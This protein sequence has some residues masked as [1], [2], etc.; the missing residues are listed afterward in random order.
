M[1]LLNDN[2]FRLPHG[3][4]DKEFTD[5]CNFFKSKIA[6]GLAK[7][8]REFMVA[9]YIGGDYWDWCDLDLPTKVLYENRVRYYKEYKNYSDWDERAIRQAGIDAGWIFK[10]VIHNLATDFKLVHVGRKGL[11]TNKYIVADSTQKRYLEYDID[12]SHVF[13]NKVYGISITE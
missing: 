2:Y 9:D 5:I 7:G 8:K 12:P 13:V 6:K 10:W 11:S 4:D 3:I 1:G